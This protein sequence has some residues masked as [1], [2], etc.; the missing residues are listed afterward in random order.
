[1]LT[2]NKQGVYMFEDVS[3]RDLMFINF[4]GRPDNYNKKG[5][6][7]SF[8]VRLSEEEADMLAEDGI[9]VKMYTPKNVDIDPYPVMKCR[10][11]NDSQWPTKI[12]VHNPSSG[13][14]IP[15]RSDEMRQLIDSI[16]IQKVDFTFTRS[17]PNGDDDRRTAYVQSIV[18]TQEP[19]LLADKYGFNWADDEY[20]D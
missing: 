15:V 5:A 13:K 20:D 2:V 19:D 18:I 4:S 7:P 1:M 17:K 9:R 8:T 14:T 11:F 3:G 6:N 16:R 10:V 12:A